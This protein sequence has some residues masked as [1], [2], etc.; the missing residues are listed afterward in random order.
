[1]ISIHHQYPRKY[2]SWE[3]MGVASGL[4]IKVAYLLGR[5]AAVLLLDCIIDG[6]VC[7]LLSLQGIDIVGSNSKGGLHFRLPTNNKIQGAFKC[8][9]QYHNKQCIDIG[10]IHLV[11][12]NLHDIQ[13]IMDYTSIEDVLFLSN[14]NP[15]SHLLFEVL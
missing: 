4:T 15:Q 13:N 11:F 10:S 8:S 9:M 6:L 1:M 14:L 2:S 7:N 5:T 12:A 3:K